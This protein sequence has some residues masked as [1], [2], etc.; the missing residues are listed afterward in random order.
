MARNIQV[1]ELLWWNQSFSEHLC[2]EFISRY[3]DE[4]VVVIKSFGAYPSLVY[5]ASAVNGTPLTPDMGFG[6]DKKLGHEWG[7]DWFL[8][9]PFREAIWRR[10]HAKIPL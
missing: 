10:R 7:Q 1:G 2:G 3:L 9:D 4:P 8:R 5:V 6:V